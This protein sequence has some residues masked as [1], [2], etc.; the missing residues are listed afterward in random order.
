LFV[1]ANWRIGR[2]T[3]IRLRGI[4]EAHGKLPHFHGRSEHEEVWVFRLWAQ[5]ASSLKFVR[6]SK[7]ED[8]E[9]DKNLVEGNNKRTEEEEVVEKREE[10][11]RGRR[12]HRGRN[13]K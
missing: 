5:L 11:C 4:T 13:I 3:K 1:S 6:V 12:K 10:R 8:R 7:L 9:K 2:N